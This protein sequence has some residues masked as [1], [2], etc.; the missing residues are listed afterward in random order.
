M[1]R[2][3]N[4]LIIGCLFMTGGWAQVYEEPPPG[5]TT[6]P[7]KALFVYDDV[8]TFLEVFS[9]LDGA[10]NPAAV[11]QSEYL[12]KGT[13]GLKM[14]IQKYDLTA[15]RIIIAINKNQK[16][17]ATLAGLPPW[18]REQEK[19]LRQA[20]VKLKEIIPHVVFSP[21]YYLVGSFRGIGSGSTEGVLISIEKFV[22][23]EKDLA[24]LVIH[25]MIHIQQVAAIGYEKYTA[26]FDPEKEKTLLALCIREGAAEYL[27]HLVTGGITQDEAYTYTVE[28][29][30][31][32]WQRFQKEMLGSETGDW[33][34]A[35]PKNPDQ[36]MH[37]GYT[38]GFRIVQAYY[39]NAKDKAQA[40]K[41]ILSVTDYPAFL[42][43]SGYAPHGRGRSQK[44]HPS[45]KG[46]STYFMINRG[47]SP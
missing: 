20:Y 39:E 30:K 9:R 44:G 29:E 8:H 2:F 22:P 18:L 46:D 26:I 19:G 21:V 31:R 4:L 16:K 24:P 36:P 42:E 7:E 41:E 14:F 5:F 1:Q 28:N 23:A 12:D 32:L 25:E 34:W 35:R 11:I 3:V 10:E 33:M 40:V 47:I 15:D 38:L 13:S 37:I 27:A 45:K 6:D 17:I 43:R